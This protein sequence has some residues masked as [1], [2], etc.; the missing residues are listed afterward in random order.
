MKTIR[1][2][3]VPIPRG[4][5]ASVIEPDFDG[6]VIDVPKP[7]FNYTCRGCDSTLLRLAER[8]QAHGIVVRCHKCRTYNAVPLG[9]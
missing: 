6:P 8:E 7:S 1:M 4:N 5:L 2:R 3:A 9:H